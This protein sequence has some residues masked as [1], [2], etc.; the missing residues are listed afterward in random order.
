MN[1]LFAELEAQALAEAKEE[2]FASDAVNLTRLVEL[3]YPHQGYTL[4]VRCPAVAG[5][6]DKARL[7][8]SFDDLHAQV[9]SQSAPKEDA[10]IVT[11]RLQAEIEVKRLAFPRLLPGDGRAERA[12]KG[13]RQLFDVEVGRFVA[14]RIYDR[15]KLMP[16]DRI[17][18]PAIIDQFDAT[19]VVL[20]GM[21]AEMDPT[22][23]LVIQS[24]E[25][26]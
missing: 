7:K 18:G 4:P 13:E 22:G 11:F 10:E 24:S 23:T 17:E 25:A 16:G 3:R 14:A 5:D 19:S 9:Y 8:R 15:Q 12:L 26:P 21:A 1:D 6:D 2:G 20:A